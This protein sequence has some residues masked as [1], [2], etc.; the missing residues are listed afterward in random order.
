MQYVWGART[1]RMPAILKLL[2]RTVHARADRCIARHL[3]R[4][5]AEDV[6]GNNRARHC[7]SSKTDTSVMHRQHDTSISKCDLNPRL[8]ASL[9]LSCVTPVHDAVLVHEA[10]PA[11]HS[12]CHPLALVVPARFCTNS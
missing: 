9:S 4:S 7:D 10:Q 6:M 5:F 12:Q 8:I 2:Q 1:L 11:S 3:T